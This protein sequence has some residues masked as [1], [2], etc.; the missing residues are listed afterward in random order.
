[1]IFEIFKQ[2]N[3]IAVLVGTVGYFM[4]GAVWYS[5]LFQKQ[6]IEYTGIKMED[7]N[8]K[9]EF[10]LSCLGHLCSYIICSWK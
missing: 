2:I 3:W 4:L 1:M 5:F 6:W 7:G 8:S 10:L 9:K